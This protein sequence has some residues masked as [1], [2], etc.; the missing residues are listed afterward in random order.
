A[1]G[2]RDRKKGEGEAP[3]EPKRRRMAT[4]D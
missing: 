1:Q 2:A 3:A 4:G